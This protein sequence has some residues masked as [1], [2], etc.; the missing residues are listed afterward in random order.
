MEKIVMRSCNEMKFNFSLTQKKDFSLIPH[1]RCFFESEMFLYFSLFYSTNILTW[2][3]LLCAPAYID[4]VLNF[5]CCFWLH[6]SAFQV[7]ST[8]QMCSCHFCVTVYASVCF[9]HE[10]IITLGF[11]FCSLITR[12]PFKCDL[13]AGVHKK[14]KPCLEMM[15]CK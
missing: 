9:H 7:M 6:Q 10:M 11:K 3:N 2:E 4:V 13:T 15:K 8:S 5:W 1:H 14:T 12:R